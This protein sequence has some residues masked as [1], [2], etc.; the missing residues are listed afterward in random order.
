MYYSPVSLPSVLFTK[1]VPSRFRRFRRLHRFRRFRFRF[2]RFR[3]RF[4]R[5]REL[6]GS[7]R[8][9]EFSV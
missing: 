4:R 2:R 3:F 5:F 7:S 1:S 9:R 6:F 8:F